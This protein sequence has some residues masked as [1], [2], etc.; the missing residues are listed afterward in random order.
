MLVWLT[1]SLEKKILGRIDGT[2]THRNVEGH[3][4]KEQLDSVCRSRQATESYFCLINIH[5]WINPNWILIPKRWLFSTYNRSIP[6]H[7][8]N[9]SQCPCGTLVMLLL[10]MV[11]TL[12]FSLLAFFLFYTIFA[13]PSLYCCLQVTLSLRTDCFVH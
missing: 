6:L 5:P 1:Q 10:I 7:S 13:F 8:L 11:L 12:T 4:E 2:G 9:A 3:L